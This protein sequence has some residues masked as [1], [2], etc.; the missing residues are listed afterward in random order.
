L[1]I[2]G[3]PNVLADVVDAPRRD[4]SYGTSESQ[5]CGSFRAPRLPA[6]AT[7]ECR[8]VR[9]DEKAQAPW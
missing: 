6:K 8:C 5:I 1:L 4:T 2:G 7:D 9:K 3:D